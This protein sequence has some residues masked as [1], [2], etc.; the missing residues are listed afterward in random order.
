M[1]TLLLLHLHRLAKLPLPVIVL[2]IAQAEREHGVGQLPTPTV[3]GMHPHQHHPV[4][5]TLHLT[6]IGRHG[7]HKA[8][9]F[10]GGNA[11]DHGIVYETAIQF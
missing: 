3:A 11:R 4:A 8:G 10:F 2:G 1:P 6:G 7:K 9:A 5:T